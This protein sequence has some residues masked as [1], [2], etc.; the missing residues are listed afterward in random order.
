MYLN[1]FSS[2]FRLGWPQLWSSGLV[3]WMIAGSVLAQG[4]WSANTPPDIA[5]RAAML[6]NPVTGE[7]MYA[8]EPHLRLPPASTTKVLT[9]VVT[10]ERLHPYTRVLVSPRAASAVPSRIGLRAGEVVSTQ[11]LLYGLMLKSGNDAAETLAEAAGGS[12]EGFSGLMNAKAWQIGARNSHFV[13]PHGLPNEAHYSTAYDLA[14]IFR[15]AMRYPLFA[16]VVRT[17]NAALRIE[18]GRGP[19]S[20][21][22]M[23]PVR[24]TNRLLGSYEG[25]RG[26][27]T[28]FTLK[29]RR[30]FVGEVERGGVR[31]IVVVLNSPNSD[32]LWRD[33]QNLLDYGFSRH[34]L[35]SPPTRPEPRPVMVRNTPVVTP[36]AATRT[37]ATRPAVKTNQKSVTQKTATTRSAVV[38]ARSAVAA[39]PASGRTS[40]NIKANTTTSKTVASVNKTKATTVKATTKT[41]SNA[42]R[43]VAAK[44][45]AKPVPTRVAARTSK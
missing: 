13:N 41:S 32:T 39:K 14:L 40:A 37:A 28:G 18:S 23:V 22:R 16:D 30:C 9:A 34:G 3:L 44:P 2:L 8:K 26:G 42:A 1:I 36:K 25:A 12:V 35:A 15:H 11:D 31:L 45:A 21:W 20:D 29:A 5:A 43:S 19:Y 33:T 7:V 24:S 6:M 4:G 10:L 38:P 17:R 27:K